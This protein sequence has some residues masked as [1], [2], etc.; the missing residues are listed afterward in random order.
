MCDDYDDHSPRGDIFDVPDF[1]ALLIENPAAT[2][3]VRIA[4]ESMT[5]VGIF[6]QDIAVVRRDRTPASGDIV[7]AVVGQEFTMKTF[8]ARNGRT[9][10]EAAN[11]AYP[12][13]DVTDDESFEIWGCV[14][15]VI[16]DLRT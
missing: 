2:F 1:N 8:R 15:S 10:L 3:A 5:G 16:R 6:P 14:S 7:I 13:I 4:G 11:P 9:I 12:D